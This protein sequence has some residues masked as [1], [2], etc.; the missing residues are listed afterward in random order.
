MTSFPQSDGF[1]CA[2][3][4]GSGYK[5]Q[6][7]RYFREAY[8]GG[9]GTVALN[10]VRVVRARGGRGKEKKFRHAGLKS[11]SNFPLSIEAVTTSEYFLMSAGK[12]TVSNMLYGRQP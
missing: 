12:D 1:Q 9:V 6:K 11:S 10:R 3:G 2:L 5:W 7:N 4:E 8:V